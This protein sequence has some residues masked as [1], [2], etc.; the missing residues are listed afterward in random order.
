M[1]RVVTCHSDMSVK[2]VQV[3]HFCPDEQMFSSTQSDADGLEREMENILVCVS[4]CVCVYIYLCEPGCMCVCVC[5]CVCACVCAGVCVCACVV[6][7]S[8]NILN[9]NIYWNS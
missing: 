8:T 6:G 3:D 1:L 5:V 4:V 7:L 2:E 9:S